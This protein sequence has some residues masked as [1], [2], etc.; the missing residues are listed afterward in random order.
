[1]RCGVEASFTLL[2]YSSSE[3]IFI[4]FL[5]VLILLGFSGHC[6]LSLLNF[7]FLFLWCSGT[8]IVTLL[9]FLFFWRILLLVAFFVVCMGLIL[10]SLHSLVLWLVVQLPYMKPYFKLI[11]IQKNTSKDTMTRKVNTKTV[12][13]VLF[14]GYVI[15]T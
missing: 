7:L 1:M 11:N 8:C 9:D 6:V 5:C 10:V 4:G 13:T 14:L 3:I 12:V 2:D 15:I